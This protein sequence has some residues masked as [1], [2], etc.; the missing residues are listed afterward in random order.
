MSVSLLVV[1]IAQSDTKSRTCFLVSIYNLH[2]SVELEVLMSP[3]QYLIL[4]PKYLCSYS[5]LGNLMLHMAST[6]TVALDAF[7]F[8]YVLLHC[9]VHDNAH[10][11][12]ISHTSQLPLAHNTRLLEKPTTIIVG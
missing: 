9:F 12:G 3:P 2:W 5:A 11:A 8:A 4:P 10:S 7:C 1:C 6:Q